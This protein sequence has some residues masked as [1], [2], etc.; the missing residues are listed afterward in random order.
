LDVVNYLI[1]V[2]FKFFFNVALHNYCINFYPPA[3]P[4]SFEQVRSSSSFDSLI[5][6]SKVVLDLFFSGGVTGSGLNMSLGVGG[7]IRIFNQWD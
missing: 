6:Y 4:I 2:E 7:S 5:G 3:P 1:Q